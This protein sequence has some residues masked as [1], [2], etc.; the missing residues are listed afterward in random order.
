M[1]KKKIIALCLVAAT[2]LVGC[3]SKAADGAGDTTNTTTQ[4]ETAKF[5]GTK[6][7]ETLYDAT[8]KKGDVVVATVEFEDGVAKKV[9]VDVRQ[10]NGTM[11]KSE[12]AAGNYVMIEGE[13]KAWHEQMELLEN[14][15]NENGCDVSKV[16]LTGDK[17]NTDAV[18]GVSI[19][20]SAYLDAVKAVI[21]SVNNGTELKEGVTGVVEGVIEP[22]ADAKKKDVTIAKVVFNQG[23]PVSVKIDVKLEDGTMKKKLSQDGG[24]VM[25]E[26]EEKAWHEQVEELEKF[27][28]E[29]N[30][31]LSKVTLVGENGNTDAVTGVTIKVGTYLEAVQKALDEAK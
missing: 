7:Y 18:S 24:Y 27:I 11:K 30:F 12:S 29:N 16:T 3:A 22:A 26:G 20:V 28:V 23:T 25:K 2:L 8:G 19:K 5:T 31:D 9:S 6:T 1:L 13:E 4:E 21:D 14:F 15:L 10:E 17:G